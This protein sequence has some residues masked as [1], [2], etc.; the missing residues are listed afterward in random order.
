[1]RNK[2]MKM[3]EIG[4]RLAAAA[5]ILAMSAGLAAC[6]AKTESEPETANTEDQET[7]QNFFLT[8]SR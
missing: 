3:R 2:I 6:G 1:M 8:N 5:M 7:D 4:K